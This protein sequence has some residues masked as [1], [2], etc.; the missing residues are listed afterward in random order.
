MSKFKYFFLNGHKYAINGNFTILEIVT[1][2]NYNTSLLVLEHNYLI[3]NRETWDK[4]SIKNNDTL[5]I[6]TIVGGG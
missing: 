2:F 3:C 6:I 4:I 5:E 1:Y